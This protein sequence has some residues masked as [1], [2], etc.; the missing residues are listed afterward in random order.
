MANMKGKNHSNYFKENWKNSIGRHLGKPL[1]G[2][3]MR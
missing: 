2:I 3:V 1:G